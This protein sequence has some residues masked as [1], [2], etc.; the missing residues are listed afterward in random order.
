M[1]ECF[2]K[3]GGTRL[4][5]ETI[6]IL[7]GIYMIRRGYQRNSLGVYSTEFGSVRSDT[8][9]RIAM[10][11]D[12][13]NPLFV[14]GYF[15]KNYK[16]NIYRKMSGLK[17]IYFCQIMSILQM[18]V[19]FFNLIN[20]YYIHY[21]DIDGIFG[22]NEKIRRWIYAVSLAWIC[23]NMCLN[24]LLCI[25]Y[26]HVID[27]KRKE[28][29]KKICR[30]DIIIKRK[31]EPDGCEVISYY[32]ELDYKDWIYE[33]N[34]CF[35]NRFRGN[36]WSYMANIGGFTENTYMLIEEDKEQKRT[37]ILVQMYVKILEREHIDRLN[38]F[39]YKK[40]RKGLQKNNL[41]AQSPSL[42]Y[43]IYAQHCSDIFTDIF[44]SKINK[45]Q[46]DCLPVGIVLDEH[47]IYIPK[48]ECTVPDR[49]Y[50]EMRGILE[51]ILKLVQMNEDFL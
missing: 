23:G 29:F 33:I 41:P 48:L 10:R 39:L 26:T 36:A 15:R 11:D 5:G 51:E 19:L 3:I 46:E 13:T 25:Y 44:C 24:L 17:G 4:G 6:V 7:L 34:N 2:K 38:E 31:K 21:M 50:K 30:K 43:I 32:N 37:R 47:R 28:S 14:K 8:D 42:I 40:I 27:K 9:V 16:K 1:P 20:G 12:E 45:G 18:A 49:K 35:E 22:V